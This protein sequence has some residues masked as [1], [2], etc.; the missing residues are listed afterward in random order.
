M[1]HNTCFNKIAHKHYE[2]QKASLNCINNICGIGIHIIDLF[3]YIKVYASIGVK[4]FDLLY[5]NQTT[6]NVRL[7][8]SKSI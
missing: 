3:T 6:N 7:Y 8:N 4:H 1:D 2:K 5:E